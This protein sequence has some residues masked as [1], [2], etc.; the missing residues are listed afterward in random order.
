M[1]I[2]GCSVEEASERAGFP[3]PVVQI[4]EALF[5]DVR[6]MLKAGEW[7]KKHVIQPAAKGGDA[8]FAT[9][10]AIARIGA[11][12]TA[13]LMTARGG[14]SPLVG[15]DLLLDR[16]VLLHAKFQVC[17]MAPLN[18]SRRQLQFL[19]TYLDVL[20][21]IKK[22][23]FDKQKLRVKYEEEC[24]AHERALLRLRNKQGAIKP[25]WEATNAD[26]MPRSTAATA[27]VAS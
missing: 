17:M 5:F 18:S 10:L 26:G 8:D 9:L 7:V 1:V 22:I 3:P 2:A 14:A 21:K 13:K 15:A 12:A 4:A 27:E 16:E 20:E 25:K 11:P 6:P 24:R 19:R 23:E